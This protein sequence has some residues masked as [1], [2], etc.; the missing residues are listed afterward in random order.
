MNNYN[1]FNASLLNAVTADVND[2]EVDTVFKLPTHT[3]AQRDSKIN[4]L[5]AG[6]LIFNTSLNKVQVYDGTSWVNLH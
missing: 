4:P 1:R 5:V 2:L 3:T 6:I